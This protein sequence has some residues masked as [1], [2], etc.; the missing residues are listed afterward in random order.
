MIRTCCFN[1]VTVGKL[2]GG[3]QVADHPDDRNVSVNA[4]PD[5]WLMRPYEARD[6]SIMA[7]VRDRLISFCRLC[8]VQFVMPKGGVTNGVVPPYSTE[9]FCDPTGLQNE[10]AALG[11]QARCRCTAGKTVVGTTLFITSH[12]PI[13]DPDRA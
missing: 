9:L 8:G 7:T 6:F 5:G 3:V 2:R 12:S 10:V 13:V 4:H 11:H 1:C